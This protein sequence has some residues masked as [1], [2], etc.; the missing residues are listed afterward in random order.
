MDL[1]IAEFAPRNYL[2]RERLAH[3]WRE[4]QERHRAAPDPRGYTVVFPDALRYA[5][6]VSSV[7][8]TCG[9]VHATVDAA[10]ACRGL[11]DP[12]G[13]RGAIWVVCPGRLRAALV[14]A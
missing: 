4:T 3:A 10:L 12:E 5:G 1:R 9:H 7:D 14:P 8:E 2:N 13:E 11:V 6:H